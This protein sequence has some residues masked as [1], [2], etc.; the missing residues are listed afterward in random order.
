[1]AQPATEGMAGAAD[2]LVMG[3]AK[4]D[5]RA[6]DIILYDFSVYAGTQSAM[7]HVKVSRMFLHV[8][9]HRLPVIC[10]LDGGGPTRESSLEL[11]MVSS[12]MY[13]ARWSPTA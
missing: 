9:K 6:V 5:G 11:S 7:N 10:W 2:G 3:T 4:V 13:R 1:M 8:E 12:V